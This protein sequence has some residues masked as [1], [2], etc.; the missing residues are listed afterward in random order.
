M[1]FDLLT[2]GFLLVVGA[3][4]IIVLSTSGEAQMP[5]GPPPSNVEPIPTG[6]PWFG[7]W[8]AWLIV[9]GLCAMGAASVYLTR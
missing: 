5:S 9:V 8:R 6:R 1:L 2:L 3:L 4:L 7:R